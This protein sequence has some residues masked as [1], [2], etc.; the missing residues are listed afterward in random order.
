MSSKDY[1]EE[2]LHLA[3]LPPGQAGSSGD[4]AFVSHHPRWSGC[5]GDEAAVSHPALDSDP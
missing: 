1:G 2:T 3:E 4:A 5:F